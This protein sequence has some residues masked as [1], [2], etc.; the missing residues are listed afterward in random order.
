MTELSWFVVFRKTIQFSWFKEADRY[1]FNLMENSYPLPGSYES[2]ISL[3]NYAVS[4]ELLDKLVKVCSE[5][6]FDAV[7]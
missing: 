2:P 5:E 1:F 7:D 6:Q 4:Y 3:N